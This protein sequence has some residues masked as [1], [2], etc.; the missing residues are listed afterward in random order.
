MLPLHLSTVSGLMQYTS[1]NQILK[2]ERMIKDIPGLDGYKVSIDG[3]VYSKRLNKP[4][5]SKVIRSGVVAVEVVYPDGVSR[6]RAVHRLVAITFLPNPLE[7]PQVDHIDGNKQHNHANNLRWC[8]NA[9]N[10]QFRE[11]QGNSG[12]DRIS[13]KILWGDKEY[14]SIREL[15]RG[16]SEERGSK[17]D[18]VRKELKAVRYGGKMLYGKWCELIM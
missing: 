10:Q 4:M 14:P 13:S 12:K 17:V 8:T 9:E 6:V 3:V 1:N 11:E 5:S 18:T 16:I 7:L 2:G 15:A